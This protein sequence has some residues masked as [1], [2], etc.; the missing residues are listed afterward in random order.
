LLVIGDSHDNA[1]EPLLAAH[2]RDSYFVYPALYEK[3]FG[4]PLDLVDFSA[5]YHISNVI[6]VGSAET[7]FE[8]AA[9]GIS[10]PTDSPGSG[11]SGR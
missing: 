6:F 8:N 7:L 5:Q 10:E 3:E 9:G 2:F 4:R 11:A 1:M